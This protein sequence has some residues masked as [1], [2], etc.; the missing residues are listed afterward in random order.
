[1]MKQKKI[2]VY[3]DR[4]ANGFEIA[5]ACMLLIIVA[6]KVVELFLDITGFSDITGSDVVILTM[7]FDKILSAMFALVIGVE[8]TKMLCKH[9]TETVIDVLLFAIARQTIIY[10]DSTADMLVGVAAIAV[11][12]AA[13]KYLFDKDKSILK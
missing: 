5:I 10:H 8:F 7:E 3:I 1:M 12:F 11:L 9:T 4:I 6:I 13:K 2:L